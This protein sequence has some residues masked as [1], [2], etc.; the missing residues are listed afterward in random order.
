MRAVGPGDYYRRSF[1]CANSTF[2][3]I[4]L[5]ILSRI[6]YHNVMIT[7][8][9]SALACR[10]SQND[11]PSSDVLARFPLSVALCDHSLRT[12]GRHTRSIST[13]WKNVVLR[14][15]CK[16]KLDISSGRSSMLLRSACS[17]HVAL[18]S[19]V[20]YATNFKALS[21][22]AVVCSL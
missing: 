6:R 16:L 1:F 18:L 12:D 4:P 22:V 2:F 5:V 15:H 14:S 10:Y 3:H 13:T 11:D 21:S 7:G 19:F 8:S 9:G 20:L 17:M